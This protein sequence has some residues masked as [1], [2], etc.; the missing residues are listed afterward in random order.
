LLA[1]ARALEISAVYDGLDSFAVLG[2]LAMEL[3]SRYIDYDELSSKIHLLV[4][5]YGLPVP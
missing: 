4:T 2:A 1:T 5:R 3:N